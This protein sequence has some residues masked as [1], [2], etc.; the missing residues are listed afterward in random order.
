MECIY[1]KIRYGNY[2]SKM[3]SDSPPDY[4]SSV[5]AGGFTCNTAAAR[6][7]VSTNF[8]DFYVSPNE[9]PCSTGGIYACDGS[10]AKP[11][12]TLNSL[13]IYVKH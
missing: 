7:A 2:E 5:T 10:Y 4:R 11:F 13:M 1:D 9:F 6:N 12:E 3:V 8:G